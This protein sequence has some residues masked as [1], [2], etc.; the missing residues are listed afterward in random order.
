MPNFG[1]DL[2]FHV[3]D[4]VKNIVTGEVFQV[5]CDC[6]NSRPRN[7]RK[8]NVNKDADNHRLVDRDAYLDYL[9]RTL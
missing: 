2:E 6:P 9:K 4:Y 1:T 7:H 5:I 3:N 8:R